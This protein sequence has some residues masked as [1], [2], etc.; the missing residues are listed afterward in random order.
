[1]YPIS[2]RRDFLLALF[3][4][5]WKFQLNFIQFFKCFGLREPPTPIGNSDPFC[6]ERRGKYLWIF[7]GTACFTL[8]N[9]IKYLYQE[10]LQFLF[11]HGVV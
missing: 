3:S 7:S 2:H 8:I 6:G 1:M 5:F 9:Y 10:V 4:P 11:I